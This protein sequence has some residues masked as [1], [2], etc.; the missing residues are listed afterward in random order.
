MPTSG[1]GS[2]SVGMLAYRRRSKPNPGVGIDRSHPL[3]QGLL[4]YWAFNEGSP[5]SAR[6]LVNGYSVATIGSV[7]PTAGSGVDGQC[8]TFSFS[9]NCYITTTAA[10]SP[11]VW[12]LAV[13]LRINA[14]H[15]Y[16]AM[17]VNNAA[18][19]G[20]YI[21]GLTP[22]MYNN[23]DHPASSSL[24]VGVWSTLV[25][26]YDGTT[27]SY[28]IDGSGAGSSSVAS[29]GW[30]SASNKIGSDSF[31]EN[32]DSSVSWLAMWNR[33]LSPTEAKSVTSNPWQCCM[34][35][36]PRFINQAVAFSATG[37]MSVSQH[38]TISSSATSSVPTYTGT[39]TVSRHPSITSSS[40]QTYTG[41][42][43]LTVSH[44]IIPLSATP[45]V[46]WKM[47]SISGSTAPDA[48]GS[49]P[50]TI[51]GSVT[52]SATVPTVSFADTG[53][54]A[55]TGG[56]MLSMSVAMPTS[57][58]ISFWMKPTTLPFATHMNLGGNG[59]G[60][61][62]CT[63][64]S[65]LAYR[66]G[67]SYLT[68][69]AILTT[70]VWQHVAATFT[71]GT[72]SFFI[73]GTPS[74]SAGSA[75]AMGT[76]TNIGSDAGGG[77]Y[78]GLLDDYRIY[79]SVLSNSQIASLGS[80]KELPTQATGTFAITLTGTCTASRHPTI[81]SSGTRTAPT[82]T[83]TCTVSSHPTASASGQFVV[84]YRGTSSVSRHPTVS[85]SGTRSIPTYTGTSSVSRHP[86]FTSVTT[87]QAF[88][89]QATLTIG[90]PTIASHGGTGQ[91]A[92]QTLNL[93]AAADP[94]PTHAGSITLFAAGHSA[95]TTGGLL[96]SVLMY[97]AGWDNPP[98]TTLNM[99][100]S[101]YMPPQGTSGV[102]NM[103]AVGGH[104]SLPG[105]VPLYAEN[106]YGSASSDVLMYAAGDGVTPGALPASATLNMF[107]QR[108][109]QDGVFMYAENK[110]V[111]GDVDLFARGSPQAVGQVQ[112]FAYGYGGTLAGTVMMT[113]PNVTQPT[114]ASGQVT[115]A[116]PKV[117]DI[118]SGSAHL[119][120]H[121]WTP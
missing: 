58:T 74:G 39:S 30:L 111:S 10:V 64:G 109:P 67:A 57:W 62:I 3:S 49:S 115:L 120:A 54:Y 46:R 53:S 103:Y 44:P 48:M 12:T 23:A 93:F 105:S 37:T 8:L 83:G 28:F 59:T 81:S 78:D 100:A 52:Q 2:G 89:G 56:G 92:S 118:A 38:P 26:T 1:G 11:P 22:D 15:S 77:N 87:T 75:S 108:G 4:Q 7:P 94:I 121:G 79:S 73:N 98:Y 40:V 41:S 6:D 21:N 117:I 113:A 60:N 86:S 99:Y 80:G 33:A 42:A 68:T 35:P 47:D 114:T 96:S 45:T 13:R 84:V 20:L 104:P 63:S 19:F 16:Q 116:A 36:A 14:L 97:A 110:G 70:G 17:I 106:A 27:L 72:V 51:S 65:G 88:T 66:S 50:A 82:Y 91:L 102:M 76:M 5:Q 101:G 90:H 24:A 55:I 112:M 34:P 61:G 29:M 69:G 9:S 18:T 85:A 25:I 107:V 31:N 95:G 119:Y 71:G 32:L 43:T